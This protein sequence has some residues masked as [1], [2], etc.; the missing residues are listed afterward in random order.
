VK[1]N[2]PGTRAPD[3]LRWLPLASFVGSVALTFIGGLVGWSVWIT[4]N[5]PQVSYVD[6]MIGKNIKYVDMNSE[7]IVKYIDEKIA[8]LR[9]ESF[10]HSDFNRSKMESEYKELSGKMDMLILLIS[11]SNKAQKP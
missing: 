6:E 9:K 11:N 1:R 10:D 4:R 3:F 7:R 5:V 2:S 8:A